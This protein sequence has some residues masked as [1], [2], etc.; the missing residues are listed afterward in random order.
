MT[1]TGPARSSPIT[2]PASRSSRPA[3]RAATPARGNSGAPAEIAARTLA[4]TLGE[5]T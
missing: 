2:T 3:S 4:A 1:A 5:A